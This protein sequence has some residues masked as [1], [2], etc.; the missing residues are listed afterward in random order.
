[1]KKKLREKLHFSIKDTG[2]TL[3][4][5]TV[6]VLAS[7][8]LM[9][10]AENT[11]YVNLIFVLAVFMV[12][13]LTEGYF[14]GTLASLISVFGVNYVFTYPYMQLDFTLAGYPLTFMTMMFVAIAT[15]MMTSQLKEQEQLQAEAEREKMRGNL[16]RAVSHDLRTPLT[17]IIGAAEMLTL[18]ESLRKDE[19][20]RA[21]ADGIRKDA[22]WLLRMVE[23]MLSITRLESGARLHLREE[24][25]EEII[26]AAAAKFK[27]WHPEHRLSIRFPADLLMARMDGVLIEQVILNFLDNAARHADNSREVELE[28]GRQG[29]MLYI[30]VSD[31]G[32]GLEA[33]ELEN[34]RSGRPVKSARESADSSGDTHRGMG[35]GLS[36]CRTIV[37]AH[38]GSITAWN[39]P[40]GGAVFE[41]TLP[42][43]EVE[44]EQ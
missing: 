5:L 20:G 40:E 23:N 24:L 26:G 11:S 25:P 7:L 34:L 44:H 3:A 9:D 38:G 4:V 43:M 10:R 29:E 27:K 28:C 41:F 33:A 36:V 13:R 37:K 14:Y 16:L 21:L 2:I 17:S 6:A 30:R 12:S 42:L 18:S 31:H 39:R 19:D 1:M 35:I 15:S 8:L 32:R 22:D